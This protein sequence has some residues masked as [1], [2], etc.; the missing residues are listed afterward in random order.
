MNPK[1]YGVMAEFA[2]AEALLDAARR[3]RRA[4]LGPIEAYTPFPMREIAEAV[5]AGPGRV[6]LITL[7][8]GVF[9][10]TGGYFL[11]WYSAV[12]S[13]PINVGGRPL[14][15]WPSF[16]PPTFEMTILGAALACVFG[17]LALNGLPSLYHPVF[18]VDEFS[19]SS[20]N[21]FFLCLRAKPAGF[22]ADAARHFLQE[23]QPL[24]I[25]D[26]PQ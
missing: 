26:V 4:G 8:G 3:T 14:H 25:W 12:I 23:L 22:D 15:S 16:I 10:G 11:Q 7:L 17:M 2:T 5:D 24:G 20:R 21:R 1:L 18:N 6:P 19:L 9:G 13:Y